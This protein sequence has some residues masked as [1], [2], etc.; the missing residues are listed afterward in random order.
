M[1]SSHA[2]TPLQPLPNIVMDPLPNVK[3]LIWPRI[4][5]TGGENLLKMLQYLINDKKQKCIITDAGSA[6]VEDK[7]NYS[8]A[9]HEK[10]DRERLYKP[11]LMEYYQM[12]IDKHKWQKRKTFLIQYHAPFMHV[13]LSKQL[14]LQSSE[15]MYISM[16]RNPI[17]RIVS[18][19]YY[20]RG[21]SG[22]WRS[23]NDSHYNRF[24]VPKILQLQRNFD[25]D[26]CIRDYDVGEN[27]CEFSTNYY[28]KWF[29]G[30]KSHLCDP[31]HINEKSYEL[32]IQN[33]D[34]YFAW[35]GVLEYYRNS[36]YALYDRFPLFFKQFPGRMQFARKFEYVD[37]RMKRMRRDIGYGDYRMPSEESIEVLKRKNALDIKFYEHVVEKFE[38]R[39]V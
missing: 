30:A 24:Y 33:I 19:F 5:K 27:I 29:C 7:K 13:D 14:Q 3:C 38:L 1:Y 31:L 12:I 16:I 21:E 15:I 32:A 34:K 25:I 36:V 23:M 17:N 20:L 35:I 39:Q 8:F 9:P 37:E 2:D 26:E 4:P 28:V 11:E 6:Y 18:S 10:F 22:G